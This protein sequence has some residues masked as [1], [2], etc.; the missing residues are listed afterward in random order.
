MPR[1]ALLKYLTSYM[2]WSHFS[3]GNHAC[4]EAATNVRLSPYH[5][6]RYE[7]CS[8]S[9]PPRLSLALLLV[10]AAN[11]R[12][13]AFVLPPM[14]ILSSTSDRNRK[15]QQIT[16]TRPTHIQSPRSQPARSNSNSYSQLQSDLESTGPLIV[17][18]PDPKS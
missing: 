16:S 4:A 10:T 8:L 17:C 6:G 1:S 2:C 5:D 15:P 18:E 13:P 7:V 12:E 11:H 9:E 14:P 3:Q